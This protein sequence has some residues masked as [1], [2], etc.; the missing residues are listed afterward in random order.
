[1]T[2]FGISD[3]QGGSVLPS[4]SRFPGNQNQEN[5]IK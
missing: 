5:S 4:P 1:M 2:D 3:T